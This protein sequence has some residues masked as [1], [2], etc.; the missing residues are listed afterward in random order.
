MATD[1]KHHEEEQPEEEG[2]IF[3]TVRSELP[4][5]DPEFKAAMREAG[6]EEEEPKPKVE[7][8][9]TDEPFDLKTL[10]PAA[11]AYVNSQAKERRHERKAHNQQIAKL[12]EQI[13]DLAK[14][15]VAE[16]PK[17]EAPKGLTKPVMPKFADFT[18]KPEKYDEAVE[19]FHLDMAAYALAVKQQEQEQ[20][21]AAQARDEADRKLVADFAKKQDEFIEEH[22]DYE[23]VMDKDVKLSSVMFGAV[24]ENG[25]WLGYY[26]ASH[27]N[28]A[29]EIFALTDDKQIARVIKLIARHEIEEES[30]VV[31]SKG[32]EAK[33]KKEMPAPVVPGNARRIAE[34]DK[35]TMSFKEREA[36]WAKDHPGE[37][38]YM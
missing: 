8:P 9:K 2:G 36:Q 30:K 28:E 16:E 29:R 22:P 4:E 7:E 25:P 21:K 1:V 15:R 12:Q 38:N 24:V 20:T 17:V 27:E 6:A 13:D 26:F 3:T 5:N 34:K 14:G 11:L 10:S 31:K 19:K 35:S 23:E 18:D 32:G 37:L 33:P